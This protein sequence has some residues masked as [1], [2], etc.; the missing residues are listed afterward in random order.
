M[1]GGGSAVARTNIDPEQP[2]SWRVVPQDVEVRAS[3]GSRVGTVHDLLGSDNADIFHG[4]IVRLDEGRDVFVPAD[5][6][7]L[8]TG[9]HVDLTLS[10]AEVKALPDHDA[11]KTFHLGWVGIFT[12]TLGWI[13][14]KD[15]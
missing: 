10:P 14:E 12:K 1:A 15:R 9:S 2:I 6:T 13:E 5:Q 3:D 8:L 11:E 4:L 7:G